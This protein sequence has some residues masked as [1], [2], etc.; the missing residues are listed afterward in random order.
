MGRL[1]VREL[2]SG[3]P[4]TS[5]GDVGLLSERRVAPACDPQSDL[6]RHDALHVHRDRLYGLHVHLAWHDIVATE[7]PLRRL[8]AQLVFL[9]V[10][11]KEKALFTERFFYLYYQVELGSLF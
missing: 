4:V 9:V 1:G 5:R 11:P 2:A 7:I 8:I 3:V 10:L 6:C